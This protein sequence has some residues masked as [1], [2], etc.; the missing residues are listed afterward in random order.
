M[1][2]LDDMQMHLNYWLVYTVY[3]HFHSLLCLKLFQLLL[4]FQIP[5]SGYTHT[6][7]TKDDA[8]THKLVFILNYVSHHVCTF[9]KCST[10]SHI[11]KILIIKSSLTVI[12]RIPHNAFSLYAIRIL[13][14]YRPCVLKY[15][16]TVIYS[17]HHHMVKTPPF[18]PSVPPSQ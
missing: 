1:Y 5:T 8:F 15:S 11:I 2:I 9:H 3:T 4:R 6:L 17:H 7:D 14:I 10:F 18:P 16:S 12:H 13:H